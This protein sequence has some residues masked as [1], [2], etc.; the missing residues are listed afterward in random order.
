MPKFRY[1][2]MDAKG[3]EVEGMMDADNE[4]RA[5]AAIKDKGLFPT[6]VTDMSPGGGR[7]P[8]MRGMAISKT[9][10]VRAQVKRGD[11]QVK[12]PGFL[13]AMFQGKVG[14][15]Q[16]MIFTRQL[17]TLVDAGLPLLRGL[18]VLQKQ[19]KTPQFRAALQGMAESVESGSTFAEA[20]AQFPRIYT[21]F[22]INMCKAGE[23][24]GALQ[25]VLT[26]LA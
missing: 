6:S 1:V 26:R 19:E 17:A 25:T 15:K 14:A 18:H 4:N 5:L 24:S 21:P 10:P 13:G 16:I 12:M 22:Y 20:L 2:A 7:N 8:Q 9:A 23:A 11:F 3:R